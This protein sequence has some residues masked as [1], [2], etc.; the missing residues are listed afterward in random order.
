MASWLAFGLRRRHPSHPLDVSD[1]DRCLLLLAAV[2]ELRSILPRMCDLSP[3][4]TQIV[5]AWAAIEHAHG[6]EI[7]HER[8]KGN[9]A[10]RTLAL[11]RS[12]RK[13]RTA[14]IGTPALG[15]ERGHPGSYVMA[16]IW[17]HVR[18][19]FAPRAVADVEWSSGQAT[20]LLRW[21]YGRAPLHCFL[22]PSA[23][24]RL[25]W[26]LH[27][28]KRSQ[29]RIRAYGP[30]FAIEASSGKNRLAFFSYLPN[31]AAAA[32]AAEYRIAIDGAVLR[33][34]KPGTVPYSG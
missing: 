12:A 21:L 1:F 10:R 11:L 23:H 18:A 32:I 4:W 15:P 34:C 30:R 17:K 26:V 16:R 31:E 25:E 8:V 3:E 9:T 20:Y 28:M 27:D 5:G 13:H 7:G 2:P 14:H 19:A 24:G 29:V 33:A 22:G 6:E